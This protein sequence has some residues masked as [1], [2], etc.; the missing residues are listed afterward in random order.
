M[1]EPKVKMSRQGGAIRLSLPARVAND[2]GSLQK[3]LRS[4]AERLGHPNCA[5]G[6]DILH[7]MLEREFTVS[8]RLEV[9]PMPAAGPLP[10]P[11]LPSDPIP[12]RTVTVA[13][14]DKVNGDIEALT[15]TIGLVVDKLG[16]RACCSGFDILFRRELDLITVDEQLGVKGFGRFR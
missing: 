11:W 3:G 13:V 1:V 16:C 7:L 12:W 5:T 4:L 10:D 15:K 14:P 6:C 8:E 2:L 9:S